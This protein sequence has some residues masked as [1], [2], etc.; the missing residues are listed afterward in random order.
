MMPESRDS[1]RA[2]SRRRSTRRRGSRS[3]PA[4][5]PDRQRRQAPSWRS[6]RVFVQSSSCS[7]QR[8][9]HCE[10]RGR[11]GR[12]AGRE[13]PDPCSTLPGFFPAVYR[14]GIGRRGGISRTGPSDRGGTLDTLRFTSCGRPRGGN[15]TAPGPRR[16]ARALPDFRAVRSAT[17]DPRGGRARRAA[18]HR[19]GPSL[20][21][22][23]PPD[24]PAPPAQGRLVSGS[25]R[26]PGARPGRATDDRCDATPVPAFAGELRAPH[27]L[28]DWKRF[29]VDYVRSRSPSVLRKS[30]ED[31][32]RWRTT[33]PTALTGR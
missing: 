4:P 23:N 13:G 16:P 26:F 3:F 32:S 24:E 2:S 28:P 18:V 15:R 31:W 30:L 6:G 21:L 33:H 11:P 8:A 17:D 1:P 19:A 7:P 5:A 25:S 20:L 14:G 10:R 29:R 22:P 9:P 27:T 12:N